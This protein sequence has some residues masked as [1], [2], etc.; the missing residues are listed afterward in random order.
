MSYI[1]SKAGK[2]KKKFT[3]AKI[4]IMLTLNLTD[5]SIELTA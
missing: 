1:H 2:K 5:S 3:P 4:Q